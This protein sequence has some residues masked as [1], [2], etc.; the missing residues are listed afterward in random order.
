LKILQQGKISTD[1]ARF[2]ICKNSV[3]L[4]FQN[5]LFIVFGLVSKILLYILLK[6]LKIAKIPLILL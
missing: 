6:R 1:E 2:F 3:F 5:A 4:L